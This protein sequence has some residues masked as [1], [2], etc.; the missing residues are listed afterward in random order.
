MGRSKKEMQ[1]GR[2]RNS[3]GERNG[4]ESEKPDKK[5]PKPKT[6]VEGA[7][8]SLDL[9]NVC[10]TAEKSREQKEDICS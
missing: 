8:K 5:H 4:P 6:T 10:G 9:R 3:H 7:C 1:T 2:R